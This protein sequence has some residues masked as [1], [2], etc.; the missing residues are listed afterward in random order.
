[1]WHGPSV[2]HGPFRRLTALP[3]QPEQD[4]GRMAIQGYLACCCG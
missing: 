2:W 3:G 4:S 1:V